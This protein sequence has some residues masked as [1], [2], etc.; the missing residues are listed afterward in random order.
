MSVKPDPQD[1]MVVKK[2]S[3]SVL[4]FLGVTDEDFT[5]SNF[6]LDLYKRSNGSSGSNLQKFQDILNDNG[7]DEFPK[8][9]VESC[10]NIIA[11]STP[12]PTVVVKKEYSGFSGLNIPDKEVK[13]D[14]ILVKTE[15]QDSMKQE[16]HDMKQELQEVKREPQDKFKRQSRENIH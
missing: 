4:K 6:A 15:P 11:E 2:L 10:F 16:P 9:F 8:E 3:Q 5:I 14:N 13:W 7:G 12:R 1:L